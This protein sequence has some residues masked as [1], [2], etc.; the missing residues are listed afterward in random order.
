MK[1][2]ICLKGRT[3]EKLRAAADVNR[4]SLQEMAEMILEADLKCSLDI[5]DGSPKTIFYD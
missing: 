3:L 1:I 2:T 5:L 4:V